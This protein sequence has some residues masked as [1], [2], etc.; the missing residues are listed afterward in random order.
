MPENVAFL[1]L[2]AVGYPMAGHLARAGHEV[3]VYNRTGAVSERWANE[4]PGRHAA[5][6]P[7]GPASSLHGRGTTRLCARSLEREA[8]SAAAPLNLVGITPPGPRVPALRGH[9]V[10]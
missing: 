4:H 6:P 9:V 1:C 7:R 2:G 8:L 5:R 3:R 10:T